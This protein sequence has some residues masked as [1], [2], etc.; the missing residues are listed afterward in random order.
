MTTILPPSDPRLS[1]VE[2]LYSLDGAQATVATATLSGFIAQRPLRLRGLRGRIAVA[3]TAG[4]TTVEVHL[5]G[6]VISGA[7]ASV[8]NTVTDPGIFSVAVNAAIAPGD[9][10]TL[11]VTAAATAATGL[12]ASA[13][14]VR[15]FA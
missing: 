2:E 13:Y 3:G 10:I 8:A 6:T 5:N 4:T 7:T 12:V 11:V 15:D 1:Q 9:A 14:I